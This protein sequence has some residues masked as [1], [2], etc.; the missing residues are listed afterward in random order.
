MKVQVKETGAIV[1]LSLIDKNG[2][3]WISDYI[4]NWGATSD[5][6]FIRSEDGEADYVAEQETVEW[7]VKAIDAQQALDN[8]V[9]ELKEEHGSEAVENVLN[10]VIENDLMDGISAFNAAL[11]EA[12]VSEG[13]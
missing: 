7:W 10:E 9:D 3:N 5:G 1:M 2:I 12:F 8:R 6:Q 13:K 11:D 4:G